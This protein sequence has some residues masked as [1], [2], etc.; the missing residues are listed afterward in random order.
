VADIAQLLV[1]G[2]VYGSIITLGS[3]GLSL[4]YSIADFANFAHGDT[5]TVGAFGGLVGAAMLGE[6][7]TFVVPVLGDT[8]TLTLPLPEVVLFELPLSVYGGLLV[9]MVVAAVVVVLTERLV[10]R[11]LKAADAG[12]IELLITSIGIALAYR[13]IV[14]LLFGSGQRTYAI[15]RQGRIAAVDELVGVAVTPRD[16][17]IVSLTAVLVGGLHALLQYT[18]LG[19]KMR[20]TAD[21]PDLARVSGIRTRQVVVAMWVIG[22]ALAA[23]GGVLLGVDTLVRPRM[24]FDILLVVFAA[25]ILGGIGSV[26]GAMLGGFVIGFATE[27]TPA[28]PLVPNEYAPAVAFALMIAILLVR[29]EGIM[30][31]SV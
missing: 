9:G 18:T 8:Y 27:L 16:L 20:A 1:N 2:L 26:Y 5:M 25:V 11:P 28:I 4:I 3:I 30:G 7:Y 14:Q 15:V 17:V 12:S 24:G 10:Y 22:G 13:A 21:N 31:E 19:R 29:P 6:G 23:A